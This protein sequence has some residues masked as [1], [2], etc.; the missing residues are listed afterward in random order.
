M[1]IHIELATGPKSTKLDRPVGMKSAG[2]GISPEK[3]VPESERK[4]LLKFFD[5]IRDYAA[6]AIIFQ[7]PAGWPFSGGFSPM[8]IKSTKRIS[9][10]FRWRE[11]IKYTGSCVFRKTGRVKAFKDHARTGESEGDWVG[12]TAGS[13]GQLLLARGLSIFPVCRRRI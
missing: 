4:N 2:H 11:L 13:I 9:A 12:T 3:R 5:A 10:H 1:V 6:A 7:I 8:S